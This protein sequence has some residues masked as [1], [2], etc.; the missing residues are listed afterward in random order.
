MIVVDDDGAVPLLTEPALAD[1][2]LTV[3][4]GVPMDGPVAEGRN[5]DGRA[6]VG[7]RLE[8]LRMSLNELDNVP[9]PPNSGAE[10]MDL[11]F[12][13]EP[14]HEPQSPPPK[15]FKGKTKQTKR[16]KRKQNDEHGN[17]LNELD[18]DGH[19]AEVEDPADGL[20]GLYTRATQ[21]QCVKEHLD[22]LTGYEEECCCVCGELFVR[23]DLS[24][25]AHFEHAELLRYKG[26]AASLGG[27]T[28]MDD[29]LLLDAHGIMDQ[30]GQRVFCVCK[31]CELALRKNR[32]PPHALAN[33]LCLGETPEDLKDLT[34]IEM[35]LISPRRTKMNL[36]VL[37]MIEG[38][39][40]GQRAMR[41]HVTVFPQDLKGIVD[42]VLP[43]RVADVKDTI[44]VVFADD[45]LSS[46]KPST[47]Q[48]KRFFRVR[49]DK[50]QRAITWLLA[51][52]TQGAYAKCRLTQ[53][54]VEQ[55]PEDDIPAEILAAIYARTNSPDAQRMHAAYI[56]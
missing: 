31:E 54:R 16:K 23:A 7:K 17:E 20:A 49:R 36:I 42:Q 32:L 4:M 1:P 47:Q 52:R 13:A 53:E 35:A 2:A 15:A 18:E 48:L 45:K 33:N 3:T 39:G 25:V 41:G 40:T 12:S 5:V 10:P 34:P 22:S 24:T 46:V 51:H 29:G 8:K 44:Q 50:V 38:P 27:H 19:G 30:D 43:L 55:L 56:A 9:F 11:S 28:L 14:R 21:D 26:G 6:G 37:K